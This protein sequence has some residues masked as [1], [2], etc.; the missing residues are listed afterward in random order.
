MDVEYAFLHGDLHEEIYMEHPLKYAQNDYALVFH[1]NKHLYGLK[2]APWDWYAK[3]DIFLLNTGFYR[4]HS[5]PNAYVGDW[6]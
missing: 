6:V 4:C 2:Q 1:L 3:M 5:N